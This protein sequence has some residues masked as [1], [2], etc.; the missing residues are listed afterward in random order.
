MNITN[1]YIGGGGGE[2]GDKIRGD[3]NSTTT[4]TIS[5]NTSD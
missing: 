4:T 1:I 2:R 5:P 3:W